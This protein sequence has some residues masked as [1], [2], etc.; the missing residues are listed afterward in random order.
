MSIKEIANYIITHYPDSCLAMN[1]CKEYITDI[2]LEE[3]EDFFYYEKLN[4]CGCGSPSTAKICIRDYL[5]IVNDYHESKEDFK[6][7]Y[8]QERDSLQKR[9]GVTSTYDSELLLCLAYT[10]DAAG[11]TEHGSGIG[12]AW[13]TKEGKMFLWLLERNEELNEEEDENIKEW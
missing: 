1:Y 8:K 7:A 9:F 10:L 13:L 3:C 6:E 11:F 2:S 5:K 4:F 12:S